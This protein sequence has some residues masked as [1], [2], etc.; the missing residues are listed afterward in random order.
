MYNETT[1]TLQGRVGNDVVLR[2]AGGAPVANFRVA[3]TPRRFDRKNN[4]WSDGP[5]QWYSVTAWRWLAENCA[6]SLHRGDAVV[7]H[8]R[9]DMRTYVNKAGVET[10]DVQVEAVTIGHDLSRGTSTF[11]RPQAPVELKPARVEAPAA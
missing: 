2:D 10:L 6:M 5:T 1:V 4:E 11:H 9:V 8:G 3:C 7:V